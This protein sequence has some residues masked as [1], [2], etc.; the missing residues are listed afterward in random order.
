MFYKPI[1]KTLN[2][3]ESRYIRHE[4]CNYKQTEKIYAYET[5]MQPKCYTQVHDYKACWF[6]TTLN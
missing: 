5:N 6:H 3:K 2:N 4:F 1:T